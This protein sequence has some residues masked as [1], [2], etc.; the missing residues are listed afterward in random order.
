MKRSL[1]CLAVLALFLGVQTQARA[2]VITFDDIPDNGNGTQIPNGYHGLNWTNFYVL[3][4][5]DVYSSFGTNGYTN[6][7]VSSP[8][9]AFNA[10]GAPASILQSSTPFTFNS[11]YFTGAWNN[12]LNILVQAYD[13]SNNLIDQTSFVVNTTAPTLETFNWANVSTLTFT[14]SGGTPAGYNGAGEHFAMDNLT[15]NGPNTVPEP[16]SLV[17]LGMGTAG[18]MGY[19]WRRRR[20]RTSGAAA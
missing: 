12:G 1:C 18:L 19:G 5:V 3:N 17:L 14:S 15:I 8:N 20:A 4:A 9:V 10:F 16:A 2:D 11:A 6:G 7:M 13:A